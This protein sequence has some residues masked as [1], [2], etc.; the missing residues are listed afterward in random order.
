[1]ETSVVQEQWSSRLAFIFAAVGSAVGLGNIWRF[2]YMAGENGG[3]AFVI[4]YIA[5]VVFVGL[6]V[7]IAE[8]TIGRHGRMSP[9]ASIRKVAEESNSSQ[10]WGW[11]GHL[12]GLGGGLGL[13]AF[14][15]VIAGWVMA[16]IIKAASGMFAGFGAADSAAALSEF[17]A[18]TSAMAAWHFAFIAITVFIVG[19]GINAGLE[20]TVT[21]LM[22]MLF[23]LLLVLVGYAMA[24]G[25]FAEAFR[26]LFA[27]DFSRLTGEVV[28]NAAGQAFFSLS[29]ALGTMV[30]YGAYLPKSISIHRSAILIAAADTGVA[31]IAGM[32]IFPLVFAYGLSPNAGPALIFETL[33]VAFGQMPG[34]AIFGTLFFVLLAVAAVTSTISMLEPAVS[35]FKERQG[36]SRWKASIFCGSV[37]FT[38]GLLTVFS[39]GDLKEFYPLASLGIEMNFFDLNNFIVSNLIMPIGALLLATFVGWQ[40]KRSIM[41]EELDLPEGGIFKIWH[42]LIKFLCP[43]AITIILISGLT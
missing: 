2:P 19:K 37:A 21:Y 43:I 39:Y 35:Y 4:I 29:L 22:P 27:P 32:A 38:I 8:L 31:L 41:R 13:F 28:L 5:F 3:A 10:R 40:V 20:R 9:V 25:E 18:N 1:M 12:S 14:Y 17:H 11:V 6:P 23:F 24:T 33:P 36:M 26:Y 16:Y 34:G 42:V 30:A 7:L 15:S